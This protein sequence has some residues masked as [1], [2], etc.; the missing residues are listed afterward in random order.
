[1]VRAGT[2]FRT[3]EYWL[4]N[5]AVKGYLEALTGPMLWWVFTHHNIA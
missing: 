3:C 4:E 1:M 5:G 2:A